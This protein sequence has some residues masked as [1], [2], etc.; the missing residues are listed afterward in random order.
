MIGGKGRSLR[1]ALGAAA[2]VALTGA[3]AEAQVWLG[4]GGDGPR[5]GSW[6]AGGGVVW[7]AGFDLDTKDALLTGNDGNNSSPFELF[8]AEARVR[9]VYSAQGRVGF[10][11]S[12]S[13][14]FEAGVQYSRPVLE[15]RV[16]GDAEDAPDLTADERMSRYV[17]DGSLVYHM[18]GLAFA[19][20]RGVPFIAGGAGYLRELHEGEE[21]VETGTTYHAGAGVKYWMSRGKRRWG[22]RGDAGVTIRD[23]GF[24]FEDKRRVLP[25]AGVSMMFLF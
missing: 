6:E 9:P 12:P 3:R 1:V 8:A 14:A 22:V 11:L 5:R 18:R 17:I 4:G 16:S 25:T 15:V 20:G 23:G 13:L 24:D 19:G 7:T 2:L 10:Y 21:L